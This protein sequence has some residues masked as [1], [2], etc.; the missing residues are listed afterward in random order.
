MSISIPTQ[1]LA[2]ALRDKIKGRRVEV[3][4]FTTFTFD[5]GFFEKEILP[6]L[7]D[8]AF[9]DIPKIRLLLLE[10]ALRDVKQVAVYYDRRHLIAKD[11][12]VLNVQRFPVTRGTGYFHPKLALILVEDA[13]NNPA[14]RSLIVGVFSANLTQSGWWE[15]LECGEILEAVEGK[16]CSFKDDLLGICKLLRRSDTAG[17]EHAALDEIQEFI[18]QLDRTTQRSSKSVLHPRL[19]YGQTTFG[20]FLQS[21]LTLPRGVYNLEIISP[22][23]DSGHEL[24]ALT[25]LIE[26]VQPKETR[27]FLPLK[28]PGVARCTQECFQEIQERKQVRWGRLP[29][30]LLRRAASASDQDAKRFV[31]AK[32]YRLWSRSKGREYIVVGSVNMTSPAHSASNS[33]NMEVAAVIHLDTRET[34]SFWLENIGDTPAAFA[35]LDE[36]SDESSDEAKETRTP[37]IAIRYDWRTKKAEYFWDSTLP[38]EWVELSF[39]GVVRVT[40]RRIVARAWQSMPTNESQAIQGH[41]KST[42]FLCAT[43]NNG[44]SG[45]IIVEEFG[46]EYKPELTPIFTISEILR[47]WALL[48]PEQR[49]AAIDKGVVDKGGEPPHLVKALPQA[50]SFFDR[51]AGIFHAFAKLEKHITQAITSGN[52]KEAVRYLFGRRADSLPTLIDQLNKYPQPEGT[53]AT[54]Y[55]LAARYVALLTAKQLLKRLQNWGATLDGNKEWGAFIAEYRKEFGKLKSELGSIAR[56][57]KLFRFDTAEERKEFFKWFDCWFLED[58]SPTEEA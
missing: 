50:D 36:G 48:S 35:G 8:Q 32:V 7:F 29:A 20:E 24:P 30:E 47:Y 49:A 19:F 40:L 9:S 22:Y 18:N 25:Q 38:P 33:G 11:P 55:G 31:H 23:L 58:M 6:I 5:P 42:A 16:P 26:H 54:E 39:G 34:P 2:D 51:F 46:M 4:L 28:D 21:H 10:E 13:K 17:R 53:D 27:I 56:I 45:L 44:E 52:S 41:L 1:A 3:A 12:P 57:R 43:S 37:P 14:S 15:N